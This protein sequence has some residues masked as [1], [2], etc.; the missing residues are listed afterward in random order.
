V[1]SWFGRLSAS[2]RKEFVRPADRYARFLETPVRL[3]WGG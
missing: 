2:E 3:T 1:G